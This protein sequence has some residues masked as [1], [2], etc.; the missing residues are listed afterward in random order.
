MPE[1]RVL[2]SLRETWRRS[3]PSGVF[4]ASP[5]LN[6]REGE[7]VVLT[8]T[9]AADKMKIFSAFMREG[10]EKGDMVSYTCPDGERAIARAKLKEYGIEVEKHEKD[11][12]LRIDSLS[13]RFM[14]DGKLDWDKAIEKGLAQWAEAKRKGYKHVRDIED[15]GDFSFVNG[16]WRK[17]IKEYWLSPRWDD[18][19]ISESGKPVGLVYKSL[20]MEVTA[21]NVE[22]MTGTQVT[23]LLKTIGKGTLA[24][25]RFID[26][27]EDTG[28]FSRSLGLD[29]EELIGRKI[30]L[31]IDPVS[32]YEKFVKGY[33][34]ESMANVE[35]VFVFTSSA[36]PIH[37]S[38]PRQL[39][40]KFF[41]TSFSTSAPESTSEN[42]VLLPAMNMPLILEAISKV[43]E[44][45]ADASVCFV[46][47]ILS[48]LLM[49]AG[50]QKTHLFLRHALDLLA[51][52][53]AT[54][55]FLLNSSAHTPQV[56]SS[57]RTLFSNQLVYGKDGLQIVKTF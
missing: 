29:H 21:I 43:L 55:L 17:Y 9:S 42:E 46:F 51:S 53:R 41:L 32:D 31:E 16:Q 35:P 40:I 50:Q 47:D 37:S 1:F 20:I 30:L 26:L 2:D 34:K 12:A 6:L 24:P 15:V 25:A 8:Y 18:P 13:E 57:T 38:L 45:H 27:L 52:K 28:S 4:K 36:S 3:I 39:A 7:A 14:P 11:G 22:N 33:V 49:S 56:V 23:E 48:E 19:R 10:I 5:V 44:T 54:A